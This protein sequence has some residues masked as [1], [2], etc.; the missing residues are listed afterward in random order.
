MIPLSVFLLV[1]IVFLGIHI[2]FSLITVIQMTR[3]GIAGFGTYASTTA[4]LVIL[5]ITL[6]LCG[7][8]FLTVDWSQPF[9]LFDGFLG[10]SPFL[11]P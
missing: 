6:L 5:G 9:T 2:I 10:S 3:F 4:F 1:W 7:G 8:F 11:N